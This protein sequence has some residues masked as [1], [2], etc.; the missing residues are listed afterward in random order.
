MAWMAAAH[1]RC[2]AAATCTGTAWSARRG[3]RGPA[4][5]LPACERR[6]HHAVSDVHARR[7]SAG[8]TSSCSTYAAKP[9]KSSVATKTQSAASSSAVAAMAIGSA[10]SRATVPRRRECVIG[11]VQAAWRKPNR[12]DSF[13]ARWRS[14]LWLVAWR[15]T[16][17]AMSATDTWIIR[18]APRAG[19]D[20]DTDEDTVSACTTSLPTP[21]QPATHTTIALPTTAVRTTACQRNRTYLLPWLRHKMHGR[22]VVRVLLAALLAGAGPR[23]AGSR[24]TWRRR[25]RPAGVLW[26]TARRG[27]DTR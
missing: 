15:S 3:H 16:S 1:R 24:S 17:M 25:L 6:T 4:G 5:S 2:L 27:P 10:K 14:G 9:N 20:T 11:D 13:N 19:T 23:V 8:V 18:R 7:T 26:S 12:A 22:E 21:T